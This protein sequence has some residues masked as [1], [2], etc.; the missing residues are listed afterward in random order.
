MVVVGYQHQGYQ[1]RL[2]IITYSQSGNYWGLAL[3]LGIATGAN[4]LALAALLV[5]TKKP[6]IESKEFQVAFAS[7]EQRYAKVETYLK[8][9]AIFLDR[10]INQEAHGKGLEIIE[11]YYGLDEHILQIDAGLFRFE[12]PKDVKEY[13]ECQVVPIKKVL[14]IFVQN[15]QLAISRDL[16]RRDSRCL[17]NPC[18][19]K[20]SKCL[21]Y[22]CYKFKGRQNSIVYGFE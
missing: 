4:C 10:S 8:E 9:N 19:R 15:S 11:A 18:I 20:S 2:P 5:K 14:Q 3:T 6:L 13:Y 22:V 16:F 12:M 17:F 7:Y 21:L 1:F